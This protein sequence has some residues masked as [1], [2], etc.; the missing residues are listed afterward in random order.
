MGDY[1][2]QYLSDESI[3]VVTIFEI[4]IFEND[5]EKLIY[6]RSNLMESSHNNG[7]VQLN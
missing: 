5:T 1:W 7:R 6:H 3:T 4:S 2:C